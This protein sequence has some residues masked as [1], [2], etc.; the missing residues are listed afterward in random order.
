MINLPIFTQQMHQI[1]DIKASLMPLSFCDPLI[2]NISLVQN[3]LNYRLI[4]L[5]IALCLLLIGI[6]AGIII[7]KKNLIPLVNNKCGAIPICKVP[8]PSEYLL[9]EILETLNAFSTPLDLLSEIEFDKKKQYY[10][11]MLNNLL[12]KSNSIVEQLL[13]YE[14]SKRQTINPILIEG[15]LVDFISGCI[16]GRQEDFEKHLITTK[17]F[18]PST[19]VNAWYAPSALKAVINIL[20][21]TCIKFAQHKSSF[22]I[23]NLYLGSNFFEIKFTYSGVTLPQ[24]FCNILQV[25]SK[26]FNGEKTFSISPELFHFGLSKILTDSIS[27]KLAIRQNNSQTSIILTFPTKLEN[28]AQFDLI[29]EIR[30]SNNKVNTN[31][32]D[33]INYVA[34]KVQDLEYGGSDISILVVEDDESIRNMLINELNNY[35][36]TIEASNGQEGWDLCRRILPDIIISDLKMPKLNGLE[37]CELVKNTQETNHIPFILLTV[38][39]ST[40]SRVKGLKQGADSYIIKPFK[41]DEVKL[42]IK[43][44]LKLRDQQKAIFLREFNINTDG[45]NDEPGENSFLKRSI[46][47]IYKNINN[48]DFG[49]DEFAKEMAVS[50]ALL[51]KKIHSVSGFSVSI[52]I[53]K[54]RMKKAVELL[55]SESLSIAEISYKVGFSDPS[56][57]SKCFKE[58]Y[59]VSP[60][61]YRENR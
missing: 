30:K 47:V 55:K 24:E 38:Q 41:L 16:K 29:N 59:K 18:S 2:V 8:S 4:Q 49:P 56:F 51:Y 45:S 15:N 7:T 48:E 25:K 23:R 10:M 44:I 35:Y 1:S 37:F 57:F 5:I 54:I 20:I 34:A 53:R 6:V 12:N 27:A 32:G 36:I 42:R 46:D 3:F 11:N 31:K 26:E 50:R 40:E 19:P 22:H 58:E 43:N 17:V 9:S 52:F 14:T 39:D 21:S 61:K 60:S 13:F 33:N 28:F